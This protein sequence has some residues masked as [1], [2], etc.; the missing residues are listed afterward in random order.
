MPIDKIP[1]PADVMRMT[2]SEVAAGLRDLRNQEIRRVEGLR[3][4]PADLRHRRATTFSPAE[5]DRAFAA[6]GMQSQRQSHFELD[7]AQAR[8]AQDTK[9]VAA[10]DA[11]IERAAAEAAQAAGGGNGA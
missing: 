1:T 9:A 8:W 4:P 5:A 6:M 10:R 7:L 11:D 3:Q 2:P